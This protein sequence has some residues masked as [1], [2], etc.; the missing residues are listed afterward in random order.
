MDHQGIGATICRMYGTADL[1]NARAFCRLG[2]TMRRTHRCYA[3]LAIYPSGQGFIIGVGHGQSI[4]P[5]SPSGSRRVA[6]TCGTRQLPRRTY[7]LRLSSSDYA[8]GIEQ[9][10]QTMARAWFPD[11]VPHNGA[12]FPKTIDAPEHQ[13]H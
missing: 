6:G 12:G 8:G 10:V 11:R 7:N 1:C 2:R 9:G 3:E 5:H 4:A 13:K